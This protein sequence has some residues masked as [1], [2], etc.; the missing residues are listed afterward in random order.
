MYVPTNVMTKWVV[1]IEH[2]HRTK[3]GFCN[4]E[5]FNT[6][7]A[8]VPKGNVVGYYGNFSATHVGAMD[9]FYASW[10]CKGM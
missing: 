5:Q 1:E 9:R 7:L 2:Q 4:Q 3:K 8:I 6:G 10:N